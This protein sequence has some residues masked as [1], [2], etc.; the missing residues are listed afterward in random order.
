MNVVRM[1]A[2]SLALARERRCDS[3][4]RSRFSSSVSTTSICERPLGFIAASLASSSMAATASLPCVLLCDGG[5][6]GPA[7]P[8]PVS[9]DSYARV[10]AL[11]A[12]VASG[13]GV[14]GAEALPWRQAGADGAPELAP[15][16]WAG[17]CGME[18]STSFCP[19]PEN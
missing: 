6:G 10:M 15:A 4:F 8:G 1:V 11:A 12:A 9:G 17:I 13:V 18:R 3:A 19:T 7:A 16:R 14:G 5:G 2:I